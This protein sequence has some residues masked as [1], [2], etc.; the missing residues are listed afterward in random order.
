MRLQKGIKT[1]DPR[2]T[3]RLVPI[4]PPDTSAIRGKAIIDTVEIY[5]REGPKIDD[6]RARAAMFGM[7][8]KP[9]RRPKARRQC[10]EVFKYGKSL[11]IYIELSFFTVQWF[12]KVAVTGSYYLSFVDLYLCLRQLLDPHLE[13]AIVKRIDFAID[14]FIPFEE[15]LGNLSV[16]HKQQRK[17]YLTEG[18]S[19]SGV[20]FGKRPS[21]VKVYDKAKRDPEWA[22]R[23][24]LPGQ[25]EPPPVTRIEVSLYD[26]RVPIEHFHEL[27]KL[28]SDENF[29]P[30]ENMNLFEKVELVAEELAV[31]RPEYRRYVELRTLIEL[32]GLQFTRKRLSKNGN[33][34]RDY[35]KFLDYSDAV[36]PLGEIF[37]SGMSSFIEGWSSKLIACSMR[38]ASKEVPNDGH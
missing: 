10:L 25:S 20:Y 13:L 38:P 5:L 11:H 23:Y 24:R 8:L 28:I 27:P 2:Q 18:S 6:V 19:D 9:G 17:F 4:L 14:A 31:T 36:V 35:N 37:Q 7:Q 16:S 34:L 29:D 33:F 22:A 15:V 32:A 1:Q 12:R 3:P 30:F 26:E 21:E